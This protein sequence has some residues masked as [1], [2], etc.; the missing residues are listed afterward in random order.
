MEVWKDIVGY[1][2]KYQ[3]SNM[4]K[5][6]SLDRYVVF[7]NR[8]KKCERFMKGFYLNTSVNGKKIYPSVALH[9]DK[10]QRTFY[11]HHLVARHFLNHINTNHK[12]VIDHINNNPLDNR[13]ENLQITTARHNSSKDQKKLNRSSKYVGVSWHVRDKKWCARIVINKKLKHLGYFDNEHDAH[14]A[15]QNKLNSIKNDNEEIQDQ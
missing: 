6:R 11:V 13:V 10:K 8:F 15:Y 5:V 1:E 3:V 4:G 9:K 12:E 7:F 14:L 2:G